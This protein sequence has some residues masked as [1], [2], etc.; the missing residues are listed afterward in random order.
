[1]AVPERS[2]NTGMDERGAE[3]AANLPHSRPH[4]RRPQVDRR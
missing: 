1:V 4:P 3:G 2:R